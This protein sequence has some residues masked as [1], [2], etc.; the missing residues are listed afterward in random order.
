MRIA[1]RRQLSAPADVHFRGQARKFLVR[2]KPGVA[3]RLKRLALEGF[4]LDRCR[5]VADCDRES[6]QQ[7]RTL[8]LNVNQALRHETL[9]VTTTTSHLVHIR[10]RHA[11]ARSEGWEGK[12]FLFEKKNQKTFANWALLYP[13]RPEP[14]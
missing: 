1:K 4:V 13:E 14:R 7:A 10:E 11:Q 3:R 12:Q 2:H 9:L 5:R 8:R 6:V